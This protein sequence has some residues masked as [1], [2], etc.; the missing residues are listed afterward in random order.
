MR[1]KYSLY[2]II[3]WISDC[4]FINSDGKQAKAVEKFYV[5]MPPVIHP[6][7]PPPLPSPTF[8]TFQMH[9]T[10]NQIQML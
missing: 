9:N 7:P 6:P 1:C 4:L 5:V 8:R 2:L 3:M 10:F